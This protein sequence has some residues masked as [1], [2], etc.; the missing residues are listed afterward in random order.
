MK[1]KKLIAII[2]VLIVVVV[3][4]VIVIVVNSG[5]TRYAR[6]MKNYLEKIGYDCD[7]ILQSWDGSLDTERK[8]F[9]CQMTNH[10][11]IFKEVLIKRKADA[12]DDISY[13]QTVNDSYWFTISGDNYYE[14]CPGSF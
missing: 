1:K 4:V 11:G 12:S 5:S 2:G 9:Y 14:E 10:D 7:G 13:T 3:A 6:K 8:F